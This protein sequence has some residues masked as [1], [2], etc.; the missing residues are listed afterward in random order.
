M[1]LKARAL[2]KGKQTNDGWSKYYLQFTILS[3]NY[4]N[5]FCDLMFNDQTSTYHIGQEI[6]S[7]ELGLA[8]DNWS[9]QG[10]PC[11]TLILQQGF[12]QVHN[13][14]HRACCSLAWDRRRNCIHIQPCMYLPRPTKSIKIDKNKYEL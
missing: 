9:C 5:I 11:C 4:S 12:H 2:N 1:Y 7:L 6:L 8:C 13:Y 3:N 10:S 14:T